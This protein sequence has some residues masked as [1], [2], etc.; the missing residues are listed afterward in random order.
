MR[1]PS[2]ECPV[3]NNSVD[4]KS[5]PEHCIRQHA[6]LWNITSQQLLSDLH[7]QRDLVF[8]YCKSL[9]PIFLHLTLR[10]L[11]VHICY[12]ERAM[13]INFE[14]VGLLIEKRSRN[15]KRVSGAKAQG[16]SIRERERKRKRKMAQKRSYDEMEEE[17]RG[18]T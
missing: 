14:L 2:C 8:S 6:E 9:L 12:P 15:V 7:E 11:P 1:K 4:E 10:L 16:E 18:D 13:Q 17:S 5:L 3:C